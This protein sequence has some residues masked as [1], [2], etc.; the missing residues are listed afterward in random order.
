M[1]DQ[2]RVV[3]LARVNGRIYCTVGA[4]GFDAVVSRYV[5]DHEDPPVGHAGLSLRGDAHAHAA[6][7]RPR[8]HL[9]WDDGEY[10]GPLFLAAVG[11]TPSYGNNI[12]VTPHAK[13][14]DGLLDI[15]LVTPPS[16]LKLLARAAP[17][18]AG[19][20]RPGG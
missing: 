1:A 7:S 4:V 10:H 3:D 8:P 11:N 12:R 2:E 19:Q 18:P 20:A 17:G 16:L 9:V 6:T 14:D 13:A 15:C 5:D